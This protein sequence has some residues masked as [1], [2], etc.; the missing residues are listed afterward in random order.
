MIQMSEY[1][2]IFTEI[3]VDLLWHWSDSSLCD[4][5]A[6]VS[7]YRADTYNH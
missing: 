7:T 1:I 2:T 4:M 5:A 3:A 6:F